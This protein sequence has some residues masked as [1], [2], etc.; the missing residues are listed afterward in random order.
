MAQA[1]HL[2]AQSSV[3][4]LRIHDYQRRPVAEQA[5][6]RAQ[7][8]TLLALLL[9]DIPENSRVVLSGNGSA[10]LAF[11]DNPPAALAF[12]ERALYASQAGLNLS[13][14]IDHGPVEVVRG[15]DQDSSSP[16]D[17]LAGD[18]LATASVMA[19]AT[20]SGLLVSQNFRTALSQAKPGA[21][22][23]LVP[24][25]NFSDAGLRTYQV[26]CLDRLALSKRRRLYIIV[27]ISIFLLLMTATWVLRISFEDRPRLLAPY[28]TMDAESPTPKHSGRLPYGKR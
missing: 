19:A 21:E 26:Y 24:A 4:M 3:I 20:E 22:Y 27:A 25:D 17:A 9:P 5:R 1:G 16:D 2:P 13:I 15:N 23:A 6:L 10:A 18:G 12:A 8:D 28:F 11:L 14:G 7:L